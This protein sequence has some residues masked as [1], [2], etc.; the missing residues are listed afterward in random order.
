MPP[1]VL[2]PLKGSW[3]F[4]TTITTMITTIITTTP[5]PTPIPMYIIYNQRPGT[6]FSH[7]GER[8]QAVV[9][10]NLEAVP[11]SSSEPANT[12]LI[13]GR[14]SCYH[15][16]AVRL[17]G[18]Q[19]H[20]QHDNE[21]LTLTRNPNE[22]KRNLKKKVVQ[23]QERDDKGD[24][25]CRPPSPLVFRAPED[26]A[27]NAIQKAWPSKQADDGQCTHCMIA[28]QIVKHQCSSN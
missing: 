8:Q 9:S 25:D 26:V 10:L 1:A 22:W 21:G 20:E 18:L 27:L 14:W 17:T 7:Q 13:V 3:F 6:R 12:N 16:V 28:A 24:F 11:T 4:L 19:V 5:T 23:I 2:V 15:N